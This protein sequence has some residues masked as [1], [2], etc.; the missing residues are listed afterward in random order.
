[1]TL[2]VQSNAS[3]IKLINTSNRAGNLLK[4][5]VHGLSEGVGMSAPRD[6]AGAFEMEGSFAQPVDFIR[7]NPTLLEE[8]PAEETD[9]FLASASGLARMGGLFQTMKDTP[10]INPEEALNSAQN[11][12]LAISGNPMLAMDAQANQRAISV[13]K[14]LE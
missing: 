11:A 9:Q 13:M 14:L 3:S 4:T 8:P 10:S 1:M 5:A 2:Q 6:D 12:R 7:K